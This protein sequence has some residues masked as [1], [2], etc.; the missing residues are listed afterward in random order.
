MPR[1]YHF[2]N[3]SSY[4]SLIMPSSFYRLILS[5]VFLLGAS[6]AW[7]YDFEKDGI[8]YDINSDGISVSITYK[9]RG[10]YT[11]SVVIPESVTHSSTEYAVTSIGAMAFYNC[12]SL[13]SVTIPSSVTSIGGGLSPCAARFSLSPSPAQS[14]S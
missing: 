8:Y 6:A 11:G 12:S 7:A 1:S 5:V 14:R 10:G 4:N 13:Q 3:R 2:G 9:E